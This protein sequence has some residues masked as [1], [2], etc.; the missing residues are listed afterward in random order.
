MDY[1][2]DVVNVEPTLLAVVRR[3]ASSQDLSA[4]IPKSLDVVYEFLKASNIQHLGINVVVYFDNQISMEIGVKVLSKF[5]S[6]ELVQCSYTPS[7]VAAI[8]VHFGDY[9]ELSKA[10]KAVIAWC[11]RNNKSLNSISWE[12]YG[13]WNDDPQKLRTDV[14]YLIK[15]S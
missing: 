2:V 8:T 15:E 4:V 1:Q 14:H 11:G 5:K 7:G 13:H 3:R 9:S 12:V 10:H 6:T